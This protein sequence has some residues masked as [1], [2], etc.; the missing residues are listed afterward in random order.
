MCDCGC[1]TCDKHMMLNESLA[2][3]QI[4]SEGLKIPYGQ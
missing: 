3:R 4:L 1:N 2:P